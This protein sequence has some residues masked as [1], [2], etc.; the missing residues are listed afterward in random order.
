MEGEKVR[1]KGKRKREEKRV[2]CFLDEE[3][4]DVNV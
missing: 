2:N 1:K 3:R 4:I